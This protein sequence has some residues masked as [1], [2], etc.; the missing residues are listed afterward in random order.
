VSDDNAR[1]SATLAQVSRRRGASSL[2]VLSAARESRA[3]S[4]RS[5]A[6]TLSAVLLAALCASSTLAQTGNDPP[7]TWAAAVSKQI[8]AHSFDDALTTSSL[9][10]EYWP[11]DMNLLDLA[12]LAALENGDKD[13]A[14]WYATLALDKLRETVDPNAK[15]P[16]PKL[17]ELERRIADLDPLGG[18]GKQIVG[19][20]SNALLALGRNVGKRKLFVNGVDLLTRSRDLGLGATAE[21]ELAKIYD[22]KKAVE[23]LLD[24]GLD[25]P[26]KSKRKKR[27]PEQI[28]KDDA[29]HA[30][31]ETCYE[32]KG[33]NYTIKTDMGEEMAEA[34][35]QAMELM[36]GFYR[37]VFHVKERGG[38]TARVTISVYKNRA[39]F[40]KNENN[41][42]KNILGFFVPNVNRVATYDPREHGYALSEL[43]STLFHESSHQFT[44]LISADLIPAWLNEG[45][46]SYFEGAKLRT[47][48]SVETNL[49]PEGRLADLEAELKLGTPTLKDVVSFFK[50]GSY[51]GDYYAFGWGLVYFLQNYEND[52]CERVYVPLYQ[53]YM[54]AYGSGGKH[55]P[56]ERFVEYF[57]T[58]A[59]Q[60]GIAT[61]DDFEKRWQE[62]IHNLHGLY[63]GPAAKADD[64]LAR[65][66]A[67]VANKKFDAAIESYR[68]ALRKRPVD[69][70]ANV[71]LADV[72]A[73]QKQND[74][75]LFNYCK[76]LR[77]A[78][79]TTDASAQAIAQRCA[80]Q[81]TDL[82]E[83]FGKAVGAADAK[84]L[85]SAAEAANAYVDRDLPRAALRLLDAARDACGG[86]AQLATLR[87]KIAGDAVV[88]TLRWRRPRIEG[89]LAEWRASRGWKADSGA[90]F[91]E[92]QGPQFCAWKQELPERYRVETTL[93]PGALEDDAF[94]A[95]YFGDGG[96]GLQFLGLS[97]DGVVE[98]GRLTRKWEALDGLGIIGKQAF[99]NLKIG[100]EVAPEKVRF[101]LNDKQVGEHVYSPDELRGDVGLVVQ[102]GVAQFSD[103]RVR[104]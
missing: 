29:K 74:S 65:A 31:W 40:D 71:E 93:K 97:A 59:K 95:L 62:W 96:Q 101:F 37:Q 47:N 85:A 77:I 100:I 66:R 80:K 55:D 35:S 23:A 20:Y 44:H 54:A 24:S 69:A 27:T 7:A 76:A 90:L 68:W 26:L 43:W 67:E 64:L 12:S 11:E 13:I 6:R 19:E 22:N 78:R 72:F 57:V 58:K 18:K 60:P 28:A 104:Y 87:D 53:D 21:A 63:F 4:T 92:A 94:L 51:D 36:N 49:V 14:L 86:S 91:V 25:V 83:E 33:D 10:L 46:A 88:D 98:V 45:T 89:G 9:A 3:M 79:A 82:D 5:H 81:L 61:F 102:S 70:T 42:D 73:Q 34:M 103:F 8:D 52:K 48:G 56:F 32:I 84:L 50:P 15:E 41:P 38:K 17:S 2:R 99:D 1:R 30:T 39:E 75:A 16:P